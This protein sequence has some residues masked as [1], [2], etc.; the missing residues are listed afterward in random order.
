MIVWKLHK[1]SIDIIRIQHRAR[2]NSNDYNASVI[3]LIYINDQ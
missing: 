3:I 2:I 1:L